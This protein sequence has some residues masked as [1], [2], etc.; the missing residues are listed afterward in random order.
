MRHHVAGRKLNRPTSHRMLMLRT[1]VTDFI[2]HE[3]IRT[4]DSKAK[5]VRRMAE[6]V[7]T[8]GKKGDLPARRK[9]IS[10][11]KD[12]KITK[13]SYKQL[14]INQKNIIQELEK[15]LGQ[16]NNELDKAL[17]LCDQ[18]TQKK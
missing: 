14:Y 8:L 6:K 11:L 12:E 13:K 1:L 16:K 10:I 18:N 2:R 5:E 3:S 9:A 15:Q 7:I 17:E 4:T